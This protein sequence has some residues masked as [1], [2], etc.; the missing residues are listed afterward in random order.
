[1]E[2]TASM[3]LFS[4]DWFRTHATTIAGYGG[5]VF[6]IIFFSIT[7]PIAGQSI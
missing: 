7:T 5:V 6:C 4:K 3:K 2:Q 1:M